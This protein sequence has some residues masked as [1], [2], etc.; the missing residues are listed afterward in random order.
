M[1]KTYIV[2]NLFSIVNSGS[3]KIRILSLFWR[4]FKRDFAQRLKLGNRKSLNPKLG[5]VDFIFC[6]FHLFFRQI[7]G[8]GILFLYTWHIKSCLDLRGLPQIHWICD[9]CSKYHNP[10]KSFQGLQK[11]ATTHQDLAKPA[12]S[13]V[14]W[15]FKRDF[16]QISLFQ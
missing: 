14:S 7:D 12:T 16:A 4:L 3:E 2:W 15:L 11:H 10:A 8:R 6:R 5:T 1:T 9:A 13:A